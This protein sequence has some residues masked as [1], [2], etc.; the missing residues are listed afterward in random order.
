MPTAVPLLLDELAFAGPQPPP[1]GAVD[2]RRDGSGAADRIQPARAAAG[3]RPPGAG[4]NGAAVLALCDTPDTHEALREA[5]TDTSLIVR[6]AAE[7]SLIALK[8][9]II[10]TVLPPAPPW[11]EMAPN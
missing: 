3:R 9:P 6:E 11:Q 4:R 1:A 2:G 8:Q 5:L 7:A 10:A